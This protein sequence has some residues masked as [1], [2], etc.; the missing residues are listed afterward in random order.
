MATYPWCLQNVHNKF[1]SNKLVVLLNDF[2]D[3]ALVQTAINLSIQRMGTHLPS[4]MGT[5]LVPLP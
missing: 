3:N 1:L 5:P 2:A 4:G